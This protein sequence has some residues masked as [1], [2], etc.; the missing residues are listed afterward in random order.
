MKK[1]N[2]A[3]NI[4]ILAIIFTAYQYTKAGFLSSGLVGYWKFDEA[5]STTAIDYSGLKNNGTLTNGPGYTNGKIG[6]GLS[7][8]GSNDTVAIGAT[9]QFNTAAGT[10]T[11]WIKIASLPGLNVVYTII[12]T[13]DVAETF[14]WKLEY[15]DTS[16]VKEFRYRKWTPE[17]GSNVTYVL[18]ENTWY[19]IAATWDGT[20]VVFYLNGLNIG[21]SS[22]VAPSS[23]SNAV[24][25]G[26]DTRG[27]D[28]QVMNG[29]IDDVR[30][31]NRALS[32]SE[33]RQLYIKG[34]KSRGTPSGGL[35][36]PFIW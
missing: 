30:I 14:G 24:S 10:A 19:H 4:I 8:D 17:V 1:T 27:A 5:P 3:I 12:S 18:M 11:S 31:Y 16:G 25:I 23:G 2:L 15:R 33:M 7:F 36:S 6:Q 32:A 28:L 22:S 34:I 35:S 29:L 20:N 21:S 13:V 9:N 26:E